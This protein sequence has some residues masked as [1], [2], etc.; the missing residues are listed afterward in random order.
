MGIYSPVIFLLQL[1]FYSVV[2]GAIL[3][4]VIFPAFRMATPP[5]RRG[6]KGLLTAFLLAGAWSL[7]ST[8]NGFVL[9]TAPAN[10]A[11][12]ALSVM[13]MQG[14]AGAL[15][16]LIARI[17]A[18]LPHIVKLT[19]GAGLIVG[20]M[21]VA[22]IFLGDAMYAYTPLFALLWFF[23]PV[24][25]LYISATMQST[26]VFRFRTGQCVECGHTKVGRR[27]L[28]D[29]CETPTR[30]LCHRCRRLVDARPGEPCPHCKKTT[31]AA[32]CWSCG[33]AWEGVTLPRCPECGVWKPV[34]PTRAQSAPAAP[35][36][37]SLK[38]KPPEDD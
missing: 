31:I 20:T 15:C 28:C 14:G 34:L 3:Y 21:W 32:C 10:D 22:P 24:I 19:T 27:T 36:N 37:E 18:Q 12:L 13:C 23:A 25:A 30:H 9:S 26:R 4:L 35:E 17:A 16:G 1:A 6:G 8:L 11:L 33:Y 29:A 5:P 7:S 2:G 38:D